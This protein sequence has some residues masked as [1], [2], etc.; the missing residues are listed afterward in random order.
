MPS[1][2]SITFP[3]TAGCTVLAHAGEVDVDAEGLATGGMVG[4]GLPVARSASWSV[5]SFV[6]RYVAKRNGR[7]VKDAHGGRRTFATIDA[8]K[9]FCEE[10]D[11]SL[12]VR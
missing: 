5:M 8:A 2:A 4:G 3:T 7:M 10:Q 11:Q 6:D 1:S 12:M 9:T